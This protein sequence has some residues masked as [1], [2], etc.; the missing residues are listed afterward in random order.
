M[1]KQ[2]KLHTTPDKAAPEKPDVDATFFKSPEKT[3]TPI[4][5]KIVIE[6]PTND[7]GNHSPP[8]TAVA[9]TL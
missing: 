7:L 5:N 4:P 2:N 9:Q 6:N 1:K 8:M 3:L